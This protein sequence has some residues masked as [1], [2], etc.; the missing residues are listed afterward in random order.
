MQDAAPKPAQLVQAFMAVADRAALRAQFAG[1]DLQ[2][3]RC[4]RTV[5]PDGPGR[6]TGP[7]IKL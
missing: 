1:Q 7:Q 3:R 4:A 6:H 2:W 5:L